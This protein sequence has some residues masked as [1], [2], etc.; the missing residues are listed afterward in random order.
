MYNEELRASSQ[1][2]GRSP[3]KEQK[4]IGDKSSDLKDLYASKKSNPPGP[5]G[6]PNDPGD[7]GDGGDGGPPNP[8]GLPS[9]RG[10]QRN[11][12]DDELASQSTLTLNEPPRVFRRIRREADSL[13]KYQTVHG[14]SINIWMD[15]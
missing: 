6:P 12:Q 15:I 4:K 10:S 8:P 7:G 2:R 5:P 3:S 1:S 14:R 9:L 11:S 13:I